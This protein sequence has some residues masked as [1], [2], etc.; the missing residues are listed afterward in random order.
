MDFTSRLA[1]HNFGCFLHFDSLVFL[2]SIPKPSQVAHAQ[3]HA[4]QPF[5]FLF[6]SIDISLK[7][8]TYGYVPWLPLF[9]EINFSES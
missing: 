8:T 3:S 1:G 2:V 4:S 9:V 5:Y 6:Y 7:R